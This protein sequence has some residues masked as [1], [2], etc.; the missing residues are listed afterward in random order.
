MGSSRTGAPH[1][2]PLQIEA[3]ND[4]LGALIDRLRAMLNVRASRVYESRRIY[5]RPPVKP[6]G[7]GGAGWDWRVYMIVNGWGGTPGGRG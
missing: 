2:Y 4:A 6:T 1:A 7:P 3:A 5:D